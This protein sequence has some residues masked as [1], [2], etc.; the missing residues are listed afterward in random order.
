MRLQ[1]ARSWMTLVVQQNAYQRNE[2]LVRTNGMAKPQLE[3]ASRIRYEN[4]P[5]SAY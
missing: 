4:Q 2:E 5:V 1:K 3:I